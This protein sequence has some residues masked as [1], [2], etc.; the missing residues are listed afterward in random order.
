[1]L[2]VVNC[3]TKK[4]QTLMR[5]FEV[6]MKEHSK[7]DY[8]S[9]VLPR[10]CMTHRDPQFLTDNAR[11]ALELQASNTRAHFLSLDDTC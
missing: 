9:E 8:L 3:E 7:T 4:T 2:T 5:A 1:M 6:N 11:V 10:F